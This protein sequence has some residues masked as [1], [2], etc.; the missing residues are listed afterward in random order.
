VGDTPIVGAGTFADDRAAC[1]CTGDGESFA[2]ACTAFWAVDRAGQQGVSVPAVADAAL[3]RT[4]EEWRGTGGLI[5][6]RAD[7]EHA[8]ARTTPAMAYAIGTADGAITAGM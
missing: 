5:L 4:R 7:G 6:L 1:S 3:A 8:V 2:R